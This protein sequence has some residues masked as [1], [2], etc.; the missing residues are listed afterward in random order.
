MKLRAVIVDDEAPARKL[1]REYLGAYDTIDVVEECGDGKSAVE[2]IHR[3]EPDL[4]FLDVQ[5]PGWS[6][7]DV[8]ERL[9]VL[10]MV[11][12]CTAYEQYAV[13]AF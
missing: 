13:R 4:V 7:F 3:L 10:P 2:A 6:G 9:H 5:M 11:V 12:F 8:L 1:V